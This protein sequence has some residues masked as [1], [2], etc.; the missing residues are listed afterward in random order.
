MRRPKPQPKVGWL[1]ALARYYR[2][3]DASVF[4]KLIALVAIVYV[5][6][7][8]DLVPDVVPVVGWLDDLGVM[9]LATAWLLRVV[10]R[11]QTPDIPALAPDDRTSTLTRPRPS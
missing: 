11:Y 4:G 10:A 5:V 8:M 7:P 3:R 2:D 6:M 9:G 1:R